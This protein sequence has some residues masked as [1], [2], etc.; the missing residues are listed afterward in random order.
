[1]KFPESTLSMERWPFAPRGGGS[2]VAPL[3]VLIAWLPLIMLPALVVPLLSRI[4]PWAFMWAMAGAIFFGCKWLT[5][6]QGRGVAP[7][8]WKD[9]AYLFG[10]PGLDAKTFIG[11]AE[12]MGRPELL[13]WS[14]ALLKTLFGAALVWAA[15]SVVPAANPLV[16]G[17]IGMAGIIFLLHFGLFHLLALMWQQLGIDARPLMRAPVLATSLAN[18]WGRRWN[19]AFNQ[20]AHDSVFRPLHRRVGAP[21]AGMVAFLVSGLVHELVIS[22]PARGGY[23]LPTLYFVA[24]GA[25]LLIERSRAGGKMGLRHGWRGWGF[26]LAVTAVPAFWL[27]PP[28]FVTRVIVPFLQVLHAN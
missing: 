24:Q 19:S 3:R 13:S 16:K 23:G 4:Q 11:A 22:V 12:H 18:F 8:G 27:F 6:L 5:W 2:N 21:V 7:L 9:V 20:L 14:A 25:G 17:W 10:W 1:M 15:T 28:P 26:T